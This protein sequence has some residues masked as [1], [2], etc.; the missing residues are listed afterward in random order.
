MFYR[1]KAPRLALFTGL[2]MSIFGCA[3]STLTREPEV[4]RP[5]MTEPVY[6]ICPEND[7]VIPAYDEWQPVYDCPVDVPPN[8]PVPDRAVIAGGDDFM[9]QV[10]GRADLSIAELYF[11]E[12]E[13]G[14]QSLRAYLD[15]NEWTQASAEAGAASESEDATGNEG[16]A[17]V[18]DGVTRN[19]F[20]VGD[21]ILSLLNARGEI[22]VGD[23]VYKLTRDNAYVVH[24]ND[25][26]VLREKVPTLSSPAPAEPDPR[27]VV[28]PVET[29][30]TPSEEEPAALRS[31]APGLASSLGVHTSN[32]YWRVGNYRMHGKSYITNALFYSEAGV[33]TEWERRKL[34]VFWSNTWQAAPLEAAFSTAGLRLGNNY[35]YPTSGSGFAPDGPEAHKLITSGWFKQIR[36]TIYGTH[37]SSVGQCYTNVG[38]N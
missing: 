15:P 16:V 23:S 14:Y 28:Q 7:P 35:V 13:Q 4:A 6:G 37:T 24:V 36:G 9:T 34:F 27:I 20:P 1:W 33:R 8:P 18:N 32:C 3:D 38:T 30:D 29:T 11:L 25:L 22:Q 2:F 17:Y 19:D 10:D 31:A 21:G 12:Q 26:A 5:Q